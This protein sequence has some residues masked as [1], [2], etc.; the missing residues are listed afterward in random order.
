MEDISSK[1]KNFSAN[2]RFDVFLLFPLST[3][4]HAFNIVVN[5][6]RL[7]DSTVKK[8]IS[9]V[10]LLVADVEQYIV[11]SFRLLLIRFIAL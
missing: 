3:C 9:D 2:T 6:V 8:A 11:E 1:E 7:L 4:R 5:L 10:Y